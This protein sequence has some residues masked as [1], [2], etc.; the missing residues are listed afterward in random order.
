MFKE[1]F[2]KK[3]L[4]KYKKKVLLPELDELTPKASEHG[5]KSEIKLLEDRLRIISQPISTIPPEE[6]MHI[7][8]VCIDLYHERLHTDMGVIKNLINS[9]ITMS[10]LNFQRKLV[11]LKIRDVV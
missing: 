8:E 10:L 2:I 5:I 7:I 3:A 9:A 4:K 6:G 1:Y 11:L